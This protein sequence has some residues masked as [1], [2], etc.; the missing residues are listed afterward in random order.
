M[1]PPNLGQNP[2]AL[3]LNLCH[4]ITWCELCDTVKSVFVLL[5]SQ[6]DDMCP[7]STHSLFLSSQIFPYSTNSWCKAEQLSPPPSL[8]SVRARG[9]E[10]LSCVLSMDL[11]SL[12]LFTT[13]LTRQST[14]RPQCSVLQCRTKLCL[15]Q[16]CHCYYTAVCF[17]RLRQL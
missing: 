6:R 3:S 1:Q 5:V 2:A 16:P 8:C 11:S 15:L 14:D 10:L 9:L 4:I 7:S 17:N 12:Y 13:R